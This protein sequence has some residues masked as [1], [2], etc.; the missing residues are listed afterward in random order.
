M[1]IFTL[2]TNSKNSQ[3]KS[4]K[5]LNVDIGVFILLIYQ[6]VYDNMVFVAGFFNLGSCMCVGGMIVVSR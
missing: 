2:K 3:K 1:F 5:K 4:I 6:S